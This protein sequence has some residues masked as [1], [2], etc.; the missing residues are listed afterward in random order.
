VNDVFSRM[1]PSIDEV[2]V[3]LNI[4]VQCILD[5]CSTLCHNV[6]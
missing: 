1:Y 6:I 5:V 3:F 4:D 2:D